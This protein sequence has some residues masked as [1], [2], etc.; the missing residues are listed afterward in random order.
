MGLCPASWQLLL[1]AVPEYVCAV[2]ARLLS[3]PK[4]W[5][6][7]S[8]HGRLLAKQA[9]AVPATKLRSIVP[10]AAIFGAADYIIALR[11]SGLLELYHTSL[12][13]SFF[14]GARKGRQVMD[15]AFPASMAMEKG[16][17][18]HGKMAVAQGDVLK[19]YDFVSPLRIA[20]WLV[21]NFIDETPDAADIAAS[22]LIFHGMPGSRLQIGDKTCTIG[23]RSSGMLT[24]TRSAAIAGRIPLFDAAEVRSEHWARLG[25]VVPGLT[26]GVMS[27]VDNVVSIGPSASA[28]CAILDDLD[29]TLQSRWQLRLSDDSREF[30]V[31]RGA[32]SD[33]SDT[34]WK[35]RSTMRLL[36]HWLDDDGGTDTCMAN[37]IATI[38]ATFW[39]NRRRHLLS[40]SS[41]AKDRFMSGTLLGVARTRWARWAFT[42]AG[43]KRLDSVQRQL[44]KML[45]PTARLAT[46]T[47]QAFFSRRNGEAARRARRLGTWST[48]WAKDIVKWSRHVDRCHDE[49]AW[50]KPLLRFHPTSW[51]DQQRS[52][53]SGW[54]ESRTR[55]RCRSAGVRLRWSQ[56]L[57]SAQQHS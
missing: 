56:G 39:A 44:I 24:G 48:L 1:T 29:Q 19:F 36:G 15:V 2:L 42:A 43:A 25:L 3:D 26:C 31:P 6:S 5:D 16:Q 17:D 14:E 9:G 54:M 22:F 4:A 49:T 27:Y 46:D 23:R 38:C 40:A 28:A 33:I 8:H 35:A 47:D 32:V 55:T 50:S 10:M 30:M 51:L 41:G 52:R 13:S 21:R 18:M 11:M 45:Y 7:I 20:N 12:D 37:T 34:R 57:A 53:F